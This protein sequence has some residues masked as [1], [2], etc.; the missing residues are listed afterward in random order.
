MQQSECA[1][2]I[3]LSDGEG[4]MGGNANGKSDI[5]IIAFQCQRINST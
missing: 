5:D 2:I 3:L 1:K 4:E